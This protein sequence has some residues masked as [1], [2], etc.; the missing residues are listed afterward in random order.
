MA[1]GSVAACV[2]DGSEGNEVPL[3]VLELLLL[4][5]LAVE[6]WVGSRCCEVGR[7]GVCLA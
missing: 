4:L 6:E 2:V 7:V 5:L 3:L 1:G